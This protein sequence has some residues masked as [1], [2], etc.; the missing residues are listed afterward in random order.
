MGILYQGSRGTFDEPG[1]H[2]N[3]M[4]RRMVNWVRSCSKSRSES[5]FESNRVASSQSF[6]LSS[7]SPCS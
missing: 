6:F 1:L 3:C 5:L 7:C 4:V 2:E